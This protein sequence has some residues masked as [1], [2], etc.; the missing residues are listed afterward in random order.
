MKQYLLTSSAFGGFVLIEYSDIG[1]LNHFDA[2]Q[3]DLTEKQQLWLLKELPKEEVNI[4]RILGDSKTA[5]LEEVKEEITFEKFWN[6]YDEKIRSSKKKAQARW[7]RMG[8]IE[9]FKAFKFI[10]KYEQSIPSGVMK[11][12]AETYLNCEQWNN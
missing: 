12:Y 3:A 8:K 9:Q 4:K 2:S 7:N 6:R 11:K 5:K 1:L 10:Q